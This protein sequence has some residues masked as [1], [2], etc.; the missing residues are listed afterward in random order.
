M[1]K[2]K[3]E[4]GQKKTC[5]AKHIE[6]IKEQ[7]RENQI[8]CKEME[9][10][11]ATVIVGIKNQQK[12]NEVAVKAMELGIREMERDT[13]NFISEFYYGEVKK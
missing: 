13:K 8:A 3:K 6:G 5:V 9:K 7:S 4:A 1:G 11:I 10:G 2:E 12:K